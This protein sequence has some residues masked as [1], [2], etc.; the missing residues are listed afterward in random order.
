[1]GLSAPWRD[2]EFESVV[3]SRCL[4]RL[5]RRGL[6]SVDPRGFWLQTEGVVFGM[7]CVMRI[8]VGIELVN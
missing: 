8:P 3:K 2:R 4:L 6:L 1:M 5:L 7:K